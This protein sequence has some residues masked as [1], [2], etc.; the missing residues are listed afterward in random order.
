MKSGRSL[1]SCVGSRDLRPT[2]LPSA[3]SSL[4][5]PEGRENLARLR[6]VIQFEPAPTFSRQCPWL[7]TF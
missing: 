2:A 7:S 1:R 3:S 6:L 4:H 5:W